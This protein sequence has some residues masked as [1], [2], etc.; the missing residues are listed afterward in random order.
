MQESNDDISNDAGLRILS[1]CT[2]D[3]VA[4]MEVE[5]PLVRRYSMLTIIGVIIAAHVCGC[6]VL[7]SYSRFLVIIDPQIF[8]NTD[9]LTCSHSLDDKNVQFTVRPRYTMK[10]SKAF[11][12]STYVYTR[13]QGLHSLR[14]IYSQ[15]YIVPGVYRPRFL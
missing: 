10:L 5:E 8:P 2:G 9:T 6:Q 14:F 7:V 11:I 13:P 3:C 4:C 15:V 1:L 12:Q